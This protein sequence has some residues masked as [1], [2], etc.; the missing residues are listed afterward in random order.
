MPN[1]AILIGKDPAGH[2]IASVVAIMRYDVAA[3]GACTPLG[4]ADSQLQPEILEYTGIE[5]PGKI[6]SPILE[7]D[8]D[9]YAWR[10]YTDLV[11][12]GT[13]RSEAA[14]RSLLVTLSCIGPHTRF[15]LDVRATGDR[16]VERTPAGLRLSDPE[17]F[18]AMPMRHDRSYGGVDEQAE[19]RFADPED[20]AEMCAMSDQRDERTDSEYAYPRNPA[21]R[22]YLVDLD[23]AHGL[24]WPNLEFPSEPLDL[25]RLAAPIDQWG[26]RPYPACF[27]WFSHA[28]FPRISFLGVFPLLHE[29]RLPDAELRMGIL[30]PDLL[31]KPLIERVHH[32]FAQGAHPYLWRHRLRGDE[33][34]AVSHMSRDGREFLVQ[35]PA[36]P[37][38]IF[39]KQGSA[40]ESP[41]PVVLDCV[42][43]ET[44]RSQVSLVWRGT[45]PTPQPHLPHSW[46]QLCA[47]RVAW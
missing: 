36:R 5:Y 33:K 32:A 25:H 11:V 15:A 7:R 30:A 27:D 44:D 38:K 43:I 18:T 21:G 12:Q 40:S 10:G 35:L 31:E 37:P 29:D 4:E 22:G 9:L 47:A 1:S 28:W 42:F 2:T 26:P 3:D 41:A 17:T 16:H 14:V 13:I 20:L 39:L 6:R 46:Q 34:I 19:A 45:L 23:G 24:R 8:A